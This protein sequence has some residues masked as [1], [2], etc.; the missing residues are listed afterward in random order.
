MAEIISFAELQHRGMA[1][2]LVFIRGKHPKRF[3][4]LEEFSPV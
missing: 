4:K 1:E 2:L 3:P